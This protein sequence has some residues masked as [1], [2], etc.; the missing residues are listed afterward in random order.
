MYHGKI[1][2]IKGEVSLSMSFGFSHILWIEH[3]KLKNTYVVMWEGG[4]SQ[5]VP[6]SIGAPLMENFDA[7]IE[8][9]VGIRE[10]PK[11]TLYDVDRR[12]D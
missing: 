9:V 2:T 10:K 11:F 6:A 5:E 12:G 1:S 7:F 4:L 8:S 3:D